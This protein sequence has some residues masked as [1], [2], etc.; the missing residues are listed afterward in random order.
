[1]PPT[2][3]ARRCS[4]PVSCLLLIRIVGQQTDG[5]PVLLRSPHP[6]R[7]LCLCAW[8]ICPVFGQISSARLGQRGNGHSW[9]G[10]GLFGVGT[11]VCAYSAPWSAASARDLPCFRADFCFRSIGRIPGTLAAPFLRFLSAARRRRCRSAAR[12][13]FIRVSY[14]QREPSGRSCPRCASR[15]PSEVPADAW[16]GS[17]RAPHFAPKAQT[18]W[19]TGATVRHG[20]GRCA[21]SRTPAPE[22]RPSLPAGRRGHLR[23]APSRRR[24]ACFQSSRR[25]TASF[26]TPTSRWCASAPALCPFFVFSARI[27]VFPPSR[28]VIFVLLLRIFSCLLMI[29]LSSFSLQR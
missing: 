23:I 27:S 11:D 21:P 10:T 12:M 14:V 3:A 19:R 18:A 2:S 5:F 17:A 1:M 4:L 20:I 13:L 9:G 6:A 29:I 22:S 25:T 28:Y 15:C 26:S 8:Q 16:A 24:R 7:I